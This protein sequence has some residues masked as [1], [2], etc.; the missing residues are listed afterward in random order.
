MRVHGNKGIPN[1]VL[2]ERA[3]VD[4]AHNEA[5]R[6]GIGV[7]QHD[8]AVARDRFEKMQ[9]VCRRAVADKRLIPSAMSTTNNTSVTH[10]RQWIG[11]DNLEKQTKG[12]Q[13]GGGGRTYLPDRR[14]TILRSDKMTP[15]T[16]L[17]SS[18]KGRPALEDAAPPAPAPPWF[19]TGGGA[20]IGGGVAVDAGRPGDWLPSLNATRTPELETSVLRGL[21]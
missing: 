20:S 21:E 12:R 15:Y 18:S 2:Q 10:E 5:Q 8:E 7:A 11:L 6:L 13:M 3:G 4:G 14:L 16:S 9:L 1:D 17:A 19:S